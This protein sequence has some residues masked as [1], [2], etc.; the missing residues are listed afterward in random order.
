L[1]QAQ[2]EKR[3]EDATDILNPRVSL[4][5][6]WEYLC[7]G[8][9]PGRAVNDAGVRALLPFLEGEGTI[10]ELGG[11]DDYY[12]KFSTR[13]QR[14]EVTNISPPCDRLL[15]MTAMNLPENSVDAFMS[16]FA[17]EHIYDFNAV[18]TESFR[19][20]KP[21]GRFL[22]AVPFLYY[23]HAAP[24]DFFRFTSSALDIMLNRFDVLKKISFG[25]RE[26]AVAQFYHE[27]RQLGSRHSWLTRTAL[28]LFFLPFLIK[29]VL[30][31]QHDPTFAIT[32]L[33]LCEKPKTSD[34]L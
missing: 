1:S 15:D 19:C 23:Y 25:N 2:F 12:R 26:L 24:D 28:R 17:L 14:Y 33:Y 31:D 5:Y 21:G 27:K 7:D 18:I 20:L 13:H 10:L 4:Q 29:G 16:M 3:S 8:E 9:T 11:V 30:G 6:I 32:Q 22:L 34:A